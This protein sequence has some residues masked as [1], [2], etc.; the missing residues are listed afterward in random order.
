MEVH[1]LGPL[2]AV[3][4]ESVPIE[5]GPKERVVLARLA[6]ARGRPV[7]ED[8]LMMALWSTPPASA[9]K[10]LQGYI[11]RLRR[12]LGASAVSR[13]PAGYRLATVDLDLDRVE[14]LIVLG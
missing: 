5:L 11:H 14:G 10:T 6:A 7:S 1:V 9:R 8:V 2:R 13:D 12:G 4:D 3:N